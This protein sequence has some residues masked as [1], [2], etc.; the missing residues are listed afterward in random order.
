AG[1]RWQLHDAVPPGAGRLSALLLYESVGT[2]AA[3]TAAA[4]VGAVIAGARS[5]SHRTVTGLATAGITM[6]LGQAV[7]FV[8][9]SADGCLGPLNVVTGSCGWRPHLG[10][11]LVADTTHYLFGP[12]MFAVAVILLV[13]AGLRGRPGAPA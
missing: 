7:V 6:V 3:L 8:V 13:L 9:V 12:G 2:V 5:G 11:S 4:A 10:W 1:L